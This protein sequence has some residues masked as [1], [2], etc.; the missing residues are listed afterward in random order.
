MEIPFIFDNATIGLMWISCFSLLVYSFYTFKHANVL[1]SA[2]LLFNPIFIDLIMSQIRIAFAFS[3]LLIAYV[4]LKKN[5]LL[6]SMLVFIS[7]LIHT[8]SILLF[9]IYLLIIF[10]KD[11]V[12]DEKLFYKLMLFLPFFIV[13][14][15]VLFALPI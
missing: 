13:V 12:K 14:F 6:S 11:Y 15:M 7:I 4:F 10:V 1:L 9:A 2:I 5:R 8:V 3:V